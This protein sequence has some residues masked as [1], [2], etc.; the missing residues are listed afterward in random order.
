[1]KNITNI[2]YILNLWESRFPG[3]DFP[4]VRF[5]NAWRMSFITQ[6]I[7]YAFDVATTALQ[8]GRIAERDTERI[9]RY[10]SATLRKQRQQHQEFE[11]AIERRK[12]QVSL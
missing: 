9:G 1:M 11:D 4:E 3:L 12:S 8:S 10:I 5:M 7:D 2:E 6:E